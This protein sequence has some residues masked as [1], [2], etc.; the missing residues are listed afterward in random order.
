[1]KEVCEERAWPSGADYH[2]NS[3]C[4][5]LPCPASGRDLGYAASLTLRL[6]PRPLRWASYA[7]VICA[8][9]AEATQNKQTTRPQTRMPTAAAVVLAEAT[10]V[11]GTLA[12]CSPRRRPRQRAGTQVINDWCCLPERYTGAASGRPGTVRRCS[13]AAVQ[14]ITVS[15]AAQD[16]QTLPNREQ[17]SLDGPGVP[18]GAGYTSAP[19][20]HAHSP[21]AHRRDF[22]NWA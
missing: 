9:E 19:R 16:K 21:V 14:V 5:A 18:C 15:V 6:L 4:P 7:H 8:S 17:R 3:W 11:S 12:C 20:T 13:G 2:N 1:M 10:A 22:P